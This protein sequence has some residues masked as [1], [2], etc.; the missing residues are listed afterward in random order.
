MATTNGAATTR[1]APAAGRKLS[2][3]KPKEAKPRR[4]KILI[5]G[6]PGVGKTWTSLDF[7]NVYYIDTEGGADMAHYQSKLEAS[8]GSYMGPG[9]GSLEFEKVIEEVISLATVQHPYKTLVIDSFSKLFST[10]ISESEEALRKAD[11]K[12]EFSVEKK[13][14]IKKT[15]RLIAWLDKLDMNVI[16]ICHEKALWKNGEP[17]GETFDGWDKLEYELHLALQILKTGPSRT[18][19]VTKSRMLGFKDNDTF[20]WGYE[21][22][23]MRYGRDIIEGAVETLV[24]ATEQQVEDLKKL[25]DV[26]HVDQPTVDKWLE[27]AAAE[28]LEEMAGEH[29]QA[30]IDFLRA[31]LPA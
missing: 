21:E 7:P 15:R 11:R 25:I 14:P 2:G 29:I 18:A 6:R 20:P 27:R 13:E 22:F 3:V 26:M 17:A 10:A 12:I 23:A 5:Y 16:M 8:G 30:C 4:P 9:Q 28:T 1:T 24:L 31:K 19:K